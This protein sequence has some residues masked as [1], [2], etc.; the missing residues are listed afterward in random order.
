VAVELARAQATIESLRDEAQAHRA[1]LKALRAKKD[2]AVVERNR[3]IR[4][5]AKARAEVRALR[6][7]ASFRIGAG[8]VRLLRSPWKIVYLP[9]WTVQAIAAARRR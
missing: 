8:A 2:R 9:R 5:R 6:R 1:K 7:S 4:E 3:A